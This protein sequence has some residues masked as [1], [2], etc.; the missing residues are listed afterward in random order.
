MIA[1]RL[2]ILIFAALLTLA[3]ARAV[4]AS[5]EVC[6]SAN[7]PGPIELPDGTLYP[8]GQIRVCLTERLSPV[9]GLHETAIAGH[10]V[11]LFM[12]RSSKVEASP[13][14]RSEPVFHFIRT[15]DGI[16][17]LEA[18]SMTVGKRVVLYKLRADTPRSPRTESMRAAEGHAVVLTAAVRP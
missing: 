3:F 13:D 6:V 11:G 1:R 17:I 15:N 12:S 14:T 16:W 4:R 5:S 18:Y 7:V 8:A 9:A 10:P 2:P